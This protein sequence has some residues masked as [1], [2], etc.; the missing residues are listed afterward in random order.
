MAGIRSKAEVSGPKAEAH[1]FG[2]KE[3]ADAILE[4][5]AA[6]KRL[7]QSRLTR[8]AVVA[9]IHDYSKVNKGLIEVVLNNLDALEERW[10]KKP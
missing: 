10:L 8:K 1:D 7:N 9:L 4:I 2:G 3:I 6:V 5:S